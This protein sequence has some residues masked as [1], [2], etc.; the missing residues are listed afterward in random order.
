MHL[1]LNQAEQARKTAEQA[2]AHNIDSVFLRLVLYQ[3]AFLRGDRETMER[4]LAWAAGRAGEEDWLLSTQ[5]DTEAYFGRL[6]KGR[7]LSRRAVDSA[8]RADAKEAA[9]LWQANA[10]LREAE[11]GNTALAHQNA[12]AALVL[13]SGREVESVAAL[14]LAR[15]GDTAQA[16]KVADSLN[17]DFPRD[18]TV[19]QYWLP[20]IHSAIAIDQKNPTL[21]LQVLQTAAPYELRQCEPFQLGMM[22][23]VY[24]RGEAYLQ[25]HQG[26]EAA[27][28]FQKIMDHRGIVL[29]FPLGVLAHLGL[30]RAYLLEDDKTKASA[31]YQDF[32]VLWK[33]AD[34]DIPIYQQAKAEYARL[35]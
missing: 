31:A 6:G 25:A 3:A 29:N 21:G 7:E 15:A 2:Q 17:Q 32:L 9:A 13:A 18:T 24:L 30:A 34:T 26:A 35:Q 27:A 20:A 28:E 16:K 4:Q 14:A 10:A 8:Q 1:G 12:T 22:Y 5:S 19:Q 33:D 11:F 23:P